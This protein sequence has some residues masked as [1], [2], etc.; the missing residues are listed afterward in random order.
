M[1][2]LRMRLVAGIKR[3]FGSKRRLVELNWDIREAL[4][5]PTQ[6]LRRRAIGEVLRKHDPEGFAALEDAGGG[7]IATDGKTLS[8][9]LQ[10]KSP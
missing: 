6:E 2:P 10:G 4:L 7:Y 8:V 1:M 9:E 3:F 5:Q